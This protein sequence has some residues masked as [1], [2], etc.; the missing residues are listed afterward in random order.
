MKWQFKERAGLCR[1]MLKF[2]RRQI[3]QKVVKLQYLRLLGR[4]KFQMPNR[5]PTYPLIEVYLIERN[6]LQWNTWAL[7][8][9][10]NFFFR[11]TKTH[12]R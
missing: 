2:L 9:K 4:N 10:E 3:A 6:N 11:D 8:R 12:V 7:Q 5:A 1:D